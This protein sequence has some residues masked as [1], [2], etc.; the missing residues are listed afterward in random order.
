MSRGN[1]DVAHL[2]VKVHDIAVLQMH[3]P[4]CQLPCQL[5]EQD[6]VDGSLLWILRQR[7]A[8]SVV[9]VSLFLCWI[10]LAGPES[11]PGQRSSCINDFLLLLDVTV[12]NLKGQ[13]SCLSSMPILN[14]WCSR[15]T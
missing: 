3:Q 7:P 2:D 6:W 4:Q 10:L 14:A 12:T 8:G 9:R 1:Q 15:M 11:W 5:P 13:P